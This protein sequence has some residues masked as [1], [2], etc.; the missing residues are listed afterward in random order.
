MR[1]LMNAGQQAKTDEVRSSE[2]IERK[3][4]TER[5]FPLISPCISPHVSP[6][7]I[8]NE[9]STNALQMHPH[10]KRSYCKPYEINER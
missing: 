9:V 6:Q 5:E 7:K 2:A 3:N 4:P 10:E 8:Y 1:S